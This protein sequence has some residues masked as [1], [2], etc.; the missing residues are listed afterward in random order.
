MQDKLCKDSNTNTLMACLFILFL[1]RKEARLLATQIEDLGSTA[2]DTNPVSQHWGK[3]MQLSAGSLAKA[4]Q[5]RNRALFSS[6]AYFTAQVPGFRGRRQKLNLRMPA[7][8]QWQTG[9]KTLKN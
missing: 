9:P 7:L 1:V 3:D 8:G 2:S 6:E 5:S 4:Q